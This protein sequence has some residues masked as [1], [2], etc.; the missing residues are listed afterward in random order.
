[1]KLGYIIY[2]V[3]QVPQTL[4]FYEKAFGL[5]RTFLHESHQYGELTTGETT[6][7][8]ASHET[9]SSHGFSYAPTDPHSLAPG[10]EIA[11]TTDDVEGAYALALEAGCSAAASP[12]RKP[13]G[14]IVAY[15]RDCNGFL[16]ELCTPMG[17]L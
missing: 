2:Y 10:V 15:V 1:M 17:G 11:F 13:W 12:K 4:S 16:V 6:L 7:A 5:R 9:A 14:Q 3:E 8:F